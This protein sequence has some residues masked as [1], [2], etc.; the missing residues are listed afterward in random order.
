[1]KNAIVAPA[2]SEKLATISP[3]HIPSSHPQIIDIVM[4]AGIDR[5][6]LDYERGGHEQRNGN[7]MPIPPLP[8]PLDVVGQGGQRQ[9]VAE[10]NAK[11]GDD[12]RR[13]QER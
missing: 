11:R 8:Q 5:P 1:M 4:T 2:V 10:I 3:S 9:V 12:D 7:R 6:V 13:H